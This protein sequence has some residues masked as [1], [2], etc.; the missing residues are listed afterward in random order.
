MKHLVPTLVVTSWLM[1]GPAG[2]HAHL[3]KSTPAEGS[4][5]TS[6]PTALEMT[7]SENARLTALS[8][9]KNQERRQSINGLPSA[10]GKTVRVALPGLSPGAYT[11]S[12]RVLSPD[13]HVASGALHF[14]VVARP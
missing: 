9:R 3:E 12:W 6:S 10:S 2:A 4:A 8:I 5:L 13:G 7:F 1:S 11:V 14:T